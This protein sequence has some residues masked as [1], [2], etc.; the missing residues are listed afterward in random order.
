MLM[1]SSARTVDYLQGIRSRLRDLFKLL[2]V[3]DNI[4]EMVQNRNVVTTED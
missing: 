3:G 2:A 4:S 1:S